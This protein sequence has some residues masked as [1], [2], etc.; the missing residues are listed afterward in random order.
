MIRVGWFGYGGNHWMAEQLRDE[1]PEGTVLVTCHEYENA[2]VRWK[3]GFHESGIFEFLDSCDII[4]LPQR[5][6]QPAKSANR[7]A[8]AWSRKKACVVQ[9]NHSAYARYMAPGIN[10]LGAYTIQDFLDRIRELS[11]NPGFRSTLGENGYKT[12]CSFLHPRDYHRRFLSQ[13]E[14]PDF[15]SIII[16]HYSDSDEYLNLA[17]NSAL[18]AQGP[19]REVIVVSSSR[20]KPQRL[21]PKARLI[22]SDKRLS[23]SQANNLG[24]ISALEKTSHFLLLNDDTIMSHQALDFML[25]AMRGNTG[26]IL[27][28]YSNCD[29]GWLHRDSII[30]NGK[31][32][33]PGMSLN[34]FS[35]EDL[36]AIQ[37]TTLSVDAALIPAPFCAM[38]STLIPKPVMEKVGLLSEGY[39][40]GGED[41]DYSYRAHKFGIQ[42]YWT[43]AAFVF[44]F[45]G[46]TR[47]FSQDNN[48]LAHEEED[49]ANNQALHRRW[50][51]GLKKRLAIWTGPAWENWDLNSP[52]TQGIGGSETCAIRLAEAASRQGWAVTMI[53]QHPTAQVA[54]NVEL[55]HFNDF[56]P[57]EFYFDVYLA[58]RNCFGISPEVR[59]R[60]KFVWIHDIWMLSGQTVSDYYRKEIDR[61][62]CLSPWHLNFVAHHHQLPHDKLTI[63]PNGVDTSIFPDTNIEEKIY[64]RMQYSSSPDRGLDNLIYCLPFIRDKVPEIELDVYYGF[65]TW[66]SMIEKSGDAEGRKRIEYL[67]ELI[68]KV[69]DSVHFHD[70]INQK[71]LAEKWQKAYVWGYPTMFTETYCITAKEA[72]LSKTPIVCSNT[73]ALE[74]T[75]GQAGHRILSHPYSLEGRQEFIDQVVKLHHDKDYWVKMSQLAAQ[76]A[77]GVDWDTRWKEYWEPLFNGS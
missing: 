39:S 44:H 68:K 56:K 54:E 59:A 57:Q 25:L 14:R 38:Y 5:K 47:K 18:E 46:K 73:A 35:A 7:L 9:M 31:S 34:Q 58:S 63:I 60:K 48:P 10:C 4:I 65:Q 3:P 50:G 19:E 51:R 49:R 40:N 42:T 37:K 41:A 29:Q 70:R 13:I 11:Q 15:V 12:A 53:G 52:Y 36:Q 77:V 20:N 43:K 23:F 71:Q 75:V 66:K 24:I 8:L 62:V 2:D 30:I 64:G 32:L 67:Q 21:H 74:T 33:H 22:Y 17:V 55:V 28:P 61:F 69:E 1:M 76:G 16:P 26:F 45:G 6:V 72:Q 27:N